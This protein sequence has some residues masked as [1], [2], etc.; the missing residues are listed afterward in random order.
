MKKLGWIGASVAVLTLTNCTPKSEAPETPAKA[1]AA[2]TSGG[3]DEL[4]PFVSLLNTPFSETGAVEA[5]LSGLVA[6]LPDYAGLTWDSKTLNADT[7]AT[8]FEGLSLS[9]GGDTPFGIRFEQASIWGLETDLLA[10]RLGGERLDETGVLFTRLDGTDVSYF[11]VAE[12]MNQAFADFMDFIDE[13]L[14]PDLEFAVDDFDFTSQRLVMT[15][16]RLRSWELVKAPASLV[17]ELDEEAQALA[18]GGIHLGQQGIAIVRSIAYDQAVVAD[19]AGTFSMRQPGANVSM[20][21]SVDLSASSGVSGFDAAISIAQNGLTKQVS[22]Y[23]EVA[24]D[25]FQSLGNPVSLTLVQDASYA[26]STAD[27]IRLDKLAGFLARGEL[28]GMDER[29]LMSLGRYGFQDYA[30]KLND[31]TIFTMASGE[32][33]ADQFEWVIPSH[34]SYDLDEVTVNTT[35]L[36]GFFK[37]VFEAIADGEGLSD[38][39]EEE[40]A[41]FKLIME[42]LDKAI[43]LL[44]EHGL[45]TIT[46][47]TAMSVDWDADNSLTEL[48][49]STQSEGFGDGAFDLSIDLPIYDQLKAAMEAEDKEA[50]FEEAFE[51]SFAFNSLRLFEFDSG[52]YDKILGF[53]QA[54]GQEYSEEGWG[55]MLANMDPPQMRTYLATMIRM[56]KPA[57]EQEFPPAGEWIES[58]ASFVETGGSIELKL[59]PPT[60]MTVDLI[61]SIDENGEPSPEEI[62][63]IFGVSVTHSN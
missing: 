41:E 46:F 54:I 2:A 38:G 48:A 12:A 17:G 49:F 26:L 3:Y 40:Q 22:E 44:P 47:D 63:E 24:G 33:L 42:G 52:G 59:A 5:D 31:K 45:D 8:V 23:V 25:E 37:I 58:F 62:V 50:A 19:T 13:D 18:L 57:A 35:E 56:G 39:T 10:A 28:P 27:D 61:E 21:L 16:L 15:D 43:D 34:L 55:A 36:T 32:L 14:P 30:I 1:Q 11:G 29:D 53:A 7:G 4:T 51:E 20:E 6:A 9:L 60:P